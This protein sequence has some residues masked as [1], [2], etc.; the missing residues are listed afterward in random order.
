[1]ANKKPQPSNS[2]AA[3]ARAQAQ[4]QVKA[5]ERKTGIII[6]AVVA[7]VAIVFVG[8]VFFII[9][10]SKVPGL[11]ED[12][13]VVPAGSD[14]TGG[15]VVGASGVVNEDLPEGDV[16]RLDVYLDFMCPFC[17]LFEQTNE[18]DIAAMREAG[19]I[20]LYYHPISIL[21][22]FSSGTQY[23]TRAANAAATVAD[24]APE[25]FLD[26]SAALYANQPDEGTTGLSDEQIE[27]IAIDAGVP[28]DVAAQF[29]DGNFTKWVVAASDKASQDG[30]SGTP[31][32]RIAEPGQTFSEGSLVQQQEVPY[33]EAGVLRSY[34][35]GLE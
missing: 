2:K 12:G 34:I 1:M 26:F 35:E 19:E 29:A 4:A 25:Q 31:S 3:A 13:A 20:E 28:E 23:S 18:E 5:Q 11:T 8:I 21:D 30:V 6:A 27:L 15:I 17:N 24:L 16:V 14:D 7:V 9:N 33:M 22:R 10:S 32:I